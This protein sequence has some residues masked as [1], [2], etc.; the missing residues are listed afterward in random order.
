M[1]LSV[2]DYVRRPRDSVWE[3]DLARQLRLCSEEDR[4]AFLS[5]LLVAQPVVALDLARRCLKA[6]ASFEA[7]LESGVRQADAS[8]IRYWLEC[9]V[10]HLGFRRV[11]QVLRNLRGEFPDGVGYAVYWLP[12]FSR[13]QGFSRDAVDSLRREM[14]GRRVRTARTSG[15]R[16]LKS[17]QKL[18]AGQ[19][20][21]S[22]D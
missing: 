6:K 1:E 12:A 22:S 11:V 21:D 7:L 19:S 4:F 18:P 5:D 14:T 16:R 13:I 20:L 8:S 17:T 10:P 15:V 2:R 3:K 9:V